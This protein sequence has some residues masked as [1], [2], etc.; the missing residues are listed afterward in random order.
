[1]AEDLFGQFDEDFAR[2]MRANDENILH[3]INL[4]D[5]VSKT[6]DDLLSERIFIGTVKELDIAN[7][8]LSENFPDIKDQVEY[9]LTKTPKY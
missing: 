1:M 4:H 7:S 3:W 2:L 9:K 5:K 8:D 6:V